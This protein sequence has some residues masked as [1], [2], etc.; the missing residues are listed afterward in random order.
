MTARVALASRSHRL[1]LL[2]AASLLSASCA[3]PAPVPVNAW[4]TTASAD[5]DAAH[6]L[7][8]QAH[9]GWIDAGNPGFQ[10]LAE[11]RY[12]KAQAALPGVASS[13]AARAV[14]DQYVAGFRDGHVAYIDTTAQRAAAPGA[15][16]TP[17]GRN[18]YTFK[19]G[20][21]WIRAQD[22]VPDAAGATALATMLDGLATMRGV[23]RIVFDTRN[24]GGGNSGVGQRIFDAATGGLQ[25]DEENP[26][27]LPR[28]VAQWRV[29][30][31]SIAKM[32]GHSQQF[33]ALYGPDSAQARFAATLLVRLAA[34]RDAGLDWVDQDGGPLLTRAG[35]LRRHAVLRRF[36][37][38][39]ALVT[40]AR[41]AS[42]CLD[43]ADLV[44]LVPGAIHLGATTS[45]DTVY[46][47]VA[48]LALPSGNLLRLPMKAWRNRPR[49][50]SVPLVP[51]IPLAVDLRDDAAVYRA[52]LAALR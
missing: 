26:A 15:P 47:D 25:F 39:L 46:L 50:D 18:A 9:P 4:R 28:M 8:R 11:A 19:D 29:S 44:L 6:A 49:G 43:F 33:A 41:C 42:A 17:A 21:L 12:R 34:A 36:T 37:G 23:T 27:P 31:P 10:P 51:A 32:Q 38:T 22:F 40:D 30:A 3:V 45:S 5:L 24:N 35:M 20:T 52:T 7:V 1:A 13:A 48:D 16:A 14:L 2:L